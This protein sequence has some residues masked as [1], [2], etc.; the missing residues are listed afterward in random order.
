MNLFRLN[1]ALASLVVLL[2]IGAWAMR[3]DPEHRNLELMPDMQYSPAYHAYEPNP[4]FSE[5]IEPT[6]RG[7]PAGTI[8]R[9]QLVFHYEA[10][11]ED[12]VRAGEE[13][14]SP[15]DAGDA[16]VVEQG[17]EV[18]VVFCAMCHG[19]SG[20]GDGAVAKRGYPPPPP[21]PTGKSAE[22]KDGQLFHILTYGQGSMA[23]YAS[24]LSPDDRWRVIAYVRDM[25]A[26]A[27]V[28]VADGPGDEDDASED[29]PEEEPSSDE[30]PEND[31]AGDQP[32][33]DPPADEP[34]TTDPDAPGNEA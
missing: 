32:N 15:F 14:T 6:L 29:Q 22:M 31:E 5:D 26:K 25:Q 23:P 33:D 21:L 1:I 19:A 3:R 30:K 16:D 20:M 9:G 27:T 24:Q 34:E 18:Y 12:A 7:Q 4:N 11:T 8:A 13:L 17:R 2:L 10:T 28:E